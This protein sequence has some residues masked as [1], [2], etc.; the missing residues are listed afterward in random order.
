MEDRNRTRSSPTT[1]Y[2]PLY[3]DLQEHFNIDFTSFKRFLALHVT[4]RI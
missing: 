3:P 4:Y 1:D 2:Q